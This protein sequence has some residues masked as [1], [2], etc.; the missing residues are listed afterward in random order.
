MFLQ[1]VQYADIDHMTGFRNFELNETHFSDLPE[2][3]NELRSGGM[4]GIIILVRTFSVAIT[5]L[6]L[7]KIG[8]KL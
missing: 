7:V 5:S 1:D 4:K 6:I 3:F 2:Y 8:T